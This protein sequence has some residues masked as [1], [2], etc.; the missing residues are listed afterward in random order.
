MQ[1]GLYEA[2]PFEGHK[3]S[4]YAL[5]LNDHG[6]LM[7]AGSTDGAIRISDMRTQSVLGS[8]KGHTE[9]VRCTCI[10]SL[11]TFLHLLPQIQSVMQALLVPYVSSLVWGSLLASHVHHAV[12]KC[13]FQGEIDPEYP[14]TFAR[15][16]QQTGSRAL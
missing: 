16:D 15:H 13:S 10:P 4:V 3:G 12:V 9:N 7:A 2:K 1:S 8:L 14:I 6:N 11:T 5:A